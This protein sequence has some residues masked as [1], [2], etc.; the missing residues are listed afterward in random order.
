MKIVKCQGVILFCVV[1]VYFERKNPEVSDCGV[2]K[3]LILC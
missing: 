3:L 2:F 1:A